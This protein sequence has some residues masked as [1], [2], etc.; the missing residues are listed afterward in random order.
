MPF[1]GQQAREDVRVLPNHL[2]A[3]AQFAFRM[4]V[5]CKAIV[6]TDRFDALTPGVG[7]LVIEV[8]QDLAQHKAD[9]EQ[10]ATVID[11]AAAAEKAWSQIEVLA[12]RE[13]R[14]ALASAIAT[15]P[16]LLTLVLEQVRTQQAVELQS[17]LDHYQVALWHQ[18]LDAETRDDPTAGRRGS[19][20]GQ[21]IWHH[22]VDTASLGVCPD[23]P[24]ENQD[25]Q[26]CPKHRKAPA[27]T[28]A[29]RPEPRRTHQDPDKPGRS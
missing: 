12:A 24:G 18:N 20:P 16:E 26:S 17:K 25:R 13:K 14:R 3:L 15:D 21:N 29:G 8:L 22:L 27:Q 1:T 5:L 7:G 9:D 6:V 23:D 11:Y 4:K 28:L 10:E 2:T 19:P